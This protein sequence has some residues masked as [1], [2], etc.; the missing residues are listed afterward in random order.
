M[1][2]L[3]LWSILL[4]I[5]LLISGFIAWFWIDQIIHKGVT[6][7][8]M[9]V[10]A[11]FF[12]FDSVLSEVTTSVNSEA[13]PSSTVKPSDNSKQ[14]TNHRWE[15]TLQPP[16]KETTSSQRGNSTTNENNS[17]QNTVSTEVTR[18]E[19][20]VTEEQIY[21]RYYPAFARLEELALYR[22]DQLVSA[23]KVEY[24]NKKGDSEFSKVEFA[25]R[26]MSAAY[27]LQGEV[28][29]VFYK[30]L[31]AMR[32]ELKENKL[33][34]SLVEEAEK[35]YKDKI[36]AKKNEIIGKASFNDN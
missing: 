18:A 34:L 12:N 7:E 16:K 2:K 32:A 20:T 23:A 35:K 8:E 29:K 30:L 21:L 31:D 5:F 1:K 14:E 28:D 6:E 9:G 27:K 26:Y 17:S 33:P 3:K 24:N 36:Q 11:G 4:L 10:E 15:T 22:I 19:K 25:S 13:T